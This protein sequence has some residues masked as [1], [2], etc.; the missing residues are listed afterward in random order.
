MLIEH[1]I[2][3]YIIEGSLVQELFCTMKVTLGGQ[4]QLFIL[5]LKPQLK[6]GLAAKPHEVK[7]LHTL[8]TSTVCSISKGRAKDYV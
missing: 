7:K 6:T 5:L 2:N 3:I 4:Q 1:P 8:P